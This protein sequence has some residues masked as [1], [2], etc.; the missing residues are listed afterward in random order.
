MLYDN[1]PMIATFADKKVTVRY[2]EGSLV[3]EFRMPDRVV[4]AQVSGVGP[5]A[6]VTINMA[7]GRWRLYHIN[8]S[9]SRMGK[10]R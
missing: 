2:V 1:M 8:G 7:D 5:G 3:R 6:M 4:G 9:I 10:V